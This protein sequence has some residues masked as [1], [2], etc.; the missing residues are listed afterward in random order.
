MIATHRTHPSF[1]TIIAAWDEPVRCQS[2]YGC[3]RAAD[4]RGTL[5]DGRSHGGPPAWSA[6]P[7]RDV[8][9]DVRPGRG[10]PARASRRMSSVSW[11]SSRRL[12]DSSATDSVVFKHKWA[13]LRGVTVTAIWDRGGHNCPHSGMIW[14]ARLS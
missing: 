4:R 2:S 9:R 3:R 8:M 1:E 14:Q 6:G 13:E 7:G 10:R 12:S 11:R 5:R